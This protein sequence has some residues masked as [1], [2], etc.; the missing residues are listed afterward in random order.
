MVPA[1]GLQ[2]DAVGVCNGDAFTE[3]FESNPSPLNG[4]NNLTELGAVDRTE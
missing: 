2:R 4:T 3:N 1:I